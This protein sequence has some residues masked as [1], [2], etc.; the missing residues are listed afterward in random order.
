MKAVAIDD[1]PLALSVIEHFC[2]NVPS[3]ELVKTFTD[4]VDGLK[5]I[6][7]NDVDIVFLDINIPHLDGMKL[8]RRL[9][10]KVK[11]IFTTAY[12]N[13]AIEGFD[14]RAV[15]Y[16]LKP[17]SFERF[18]RAVEQAEKIIGLER[19]SVNPDPFIS[20]KVNYLT[21]KIP[22]KDIVF[23]EGLKDYVRICTENK[24]FVTKQTMKSITEILAPLGFMR[25]HRSFTVNKEKIASFGNNHVQMDGGKE[26][27]V[28]NQ[29]KAE[30]LDAMQKMTL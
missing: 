5:F 19:L 15:D 18:K 29:Y 25:I 27:P 20:V 6:E 12:Q 13:F 7:G 14:V 10:E 17:I 26:I 3:L 4:S 22:V 16:L 8:A 28:G 1:E 2:N 21:T 23:V 24:N 11:V 30:F 9:P